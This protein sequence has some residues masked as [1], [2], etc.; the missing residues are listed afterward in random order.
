MAMA[1]AG[2]IAALVVCV[3]FAACGG[4][5]SGGNGSVSLRSSRRSRD[6]FA[7]GEVEEPLTRVLVQPCA[8]R[9]EHAVDA[10]IP[11]SACVRPVI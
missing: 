11:I 10:P 9:E 6:E 1:F 2:A 7:E 4:G 5:G 3:G 8:H